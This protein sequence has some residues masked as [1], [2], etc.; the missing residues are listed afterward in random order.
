MKTPLRV[1]EAGVVLVRTS[2]RP[3]AASAGWKSGVDES[4]FAVADSAR[5]AKTNFSPSG[6]QETRRRS[7]TLPLWRVRGSGLMPPVTAVACAAFADLASHVHNCCEPD[8]LE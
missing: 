1:H 5:E 2:G 6:D 8:W 7:V 4:A 3:A